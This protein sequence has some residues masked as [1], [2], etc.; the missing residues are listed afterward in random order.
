MQ[1]QVQPPAQPPPQ[2]DEVIDAR[3][4]LGRL[5]RLREVVVAVLAQPVEAVLRRGLRREED[6]GDDGAE[7]AVAVEEALR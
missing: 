6:D 3:L 5:E 7:A 2:R 4:Q 1:A